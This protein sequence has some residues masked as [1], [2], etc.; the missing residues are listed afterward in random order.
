MVNLPDGLHGAYRSR[1][2]ARLV[3]EG[4]VRAAL[5]DGK[6]ARFAYG[7]VVDAGKATSLMTRAA[8]VQ[9]WAGTESALTGFT[10]LAVHGCAAAPVAPLHVLVPYNRNLDSRPGSVVH[11]GKFEEQDVLDIGGLR[12]MALDFAVTEVLARGHRWDAL[13]CADQ[14]FGSLP[15]E[16]RAE[17][18]AT[19]EDRVSQRRDPR[20]RRRARVLL[21]LASGLPESPAESWI[22]LVMTDEGLPVPVAQ[23]RILDHYGREV[24]RLDFAWP[25]FRIAV[26]YDGYAAHDGRA[27]L[28]ATR[29]EDLRRR[30]WIVIR[31]SAADLG[32]PSRLIAEIKAA[33]RTRRI[34]A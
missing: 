10:A 24:Y 28:D 12:T 6:L 8:A 5:K 26:E 22:L 19:L 33:F 13:A 31:A 30:G 16:E 17:F 3:G 20:G 4:R 14:A 9:L 25:E 27:L 34:A 18:R 32:D 21:D 15:V 7:V 23:Y 29:D 2:L 11:H 1:E